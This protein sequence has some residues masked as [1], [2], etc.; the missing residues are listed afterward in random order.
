MKC[1]LWRESWQTGALIMD[2][3]FDMK[4]PPRVIET[5]RM[6]LKIFAGTRPSTSS[7][8]VS[9]RANVASASADAKPCV[10]KSTVPRVVSSSTSAR[11][12]SGDGGSLAAAAR[13]RST[14]CRASGYAA[15]RSARSPARCQ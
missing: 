13:P 2:R 3:E 4:R 5:P 7:Q 1:V 15:R 12:R 14:C 8:R 9:A 6:P 10:E 11:V